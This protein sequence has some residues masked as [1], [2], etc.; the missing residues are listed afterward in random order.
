MVHTSGELCN[1][2][3]FARLTGLMSV[4][5]G[6]VKIA[7]GALLASTLKDLCFE[8]EEYCSQLALAVAVF[9]RGRLDVEKL[10]EDWLYP[11]VLSLV[12]WS[13]L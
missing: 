13:A 12:V 6:S 3:Q 1:L 11:D 9:L 5:S 10:D 4:F 8:A 7:P 2:L